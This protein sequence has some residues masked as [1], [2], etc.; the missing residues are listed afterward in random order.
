VVQWPVQQSP[1][2]L[3]AA[4][5]AW[6]AQRPA[7]HSIAPQHSALVRQPP[8]AP[9]QHRRAPRRI[10]Q[11]SEPQHCSS[12]VQVAVAAVPK[13]VVVGGR[14]RPAVQVK[15]GQQSVLDPQVSSMVRHWQYAVAPLR[16]HAIEPQHPPP[17]PPSVG[18]QVAVA[19]AQHDRPAAPCAQSRPSQHSAEVL[20]PAAPAGRHA[21]VVTQRPPVQREPSQQ[22]LSSEQRP[23]SAWHAQRP[24]SSQSICPQH[25]SDEAHDAP[26]RWQQRLVTGVGRQSKPEQH[27]D[28]MVQGVPGALQAA[29]A[30][31]LQL[32][33][34]LQACPAQHA[35]PSEPQVDVGIAQRPAAQTSGVAHALPG[36]HASV[37]AP[38][39]SGRRQ[40]P[41]AHSAPRSHARPLQQGWS[42][43]PHA[44]GTRQ[45]PL[46][47]WRPTSQRPS[48]HGPSDWPQATHIPLAHAPP[49]AQRSPA[50]Q[51]WPMV[52]HSLPR[53]QRPSRQSPPAQQSAEVSQ[54]PPTS[55]QQRP[56]LHP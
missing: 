15:P 43:A 9:V 24:E 54:S 19:P 2:W 37:A 48:Q 8:R 28:A 49:L 10:A 29:H 18:A 7:R 45:L 51:R 21:A 34:A 38:Q 11:L 42:T 40:T 35:R 30:P 44:T 53:S 31:L 46:L 32:S 52:P 5:A 36:Q 41:A 33:G 55:T 14:Q 47:H 26:C 56:S 20:H 50:Q 12:V 3:H 17:V 4:A 25:S 22:S 1:S 13:Q 6:Q 16:V 27:C 39:R 23:P